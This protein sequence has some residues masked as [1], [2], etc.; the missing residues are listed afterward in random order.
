[1]Y[2]VVFCCR[3]GEQEAP[4]EKGDLGSNP[5]IL[6]DIPTPQTVSGTRPD[7]GSGIAKHRKIRG[8]HFQQ[9][10]KVMDVIKEHLMDVG[11]MQI[12][13]GQ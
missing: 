2:P 10:V 9:R 11:R 8:S 7:R 4:S 6:S 3:L 13:A 12:S 1:M 5:K